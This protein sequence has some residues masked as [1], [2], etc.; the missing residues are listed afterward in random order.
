MKRLISPGRLLFLGLITVALVILYV[1]TLYNLQIV[2][3]TQN[4]IESTSSIVSE[5]QVIAPRGN[6]MDR[7]GRLL[8]S[9]RNIEKTENDKIFVERQPGVTPEELADKL[10]VLEQALEKNEPG[11]IR[12][13]MHR[14]V[15]NFCEP[16]E[17]NAGQGDVVEIPD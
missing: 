14:V 13:A 1:A 9:N 16:E 17:V 10:A 15:P 8:V 6:V 2:E 7:Y 11:A 5:E 4:Y 3:G 12:Q